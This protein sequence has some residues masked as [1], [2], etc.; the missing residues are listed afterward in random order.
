LELIEGKNRQVRRMTAAIG[1]PTL[2]LIRVR[3]GG[4]KLENLAA[5]RW[6]ILSAEER[7]LVASE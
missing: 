7:G 6:K 4:F 2:R 1:H 5:G 3:I